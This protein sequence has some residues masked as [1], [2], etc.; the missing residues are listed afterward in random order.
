MQTMLR[1]RDNLLS[2]LPVLI[3]TLICAL[4]ILCFQFEQ[5]ILGA[6][7][8]GFGFCLWFACEWILIPKHPQT[9]GTASDPFINRLICFFYFS[10]LMSRGLCPAWFLGLQI[11]TTL[12][13][14]LGLFLLNIS[15]HSITRL[16]EPLSLA[17]VTFQRTT[18]GLLFLSLSPIN[19]HYPYV[20]VMMT[21]VALCSFQVLVFFGHLKHYRV[22]L[23]R[24]LTPSLGS[25]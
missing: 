21:Y 12:L 22:Q 10:L 11:A 23:I 1:I 2:A 25:V 7:L 17:N 18:L 16:R 20:V 14:S 9:L 19:V 24:L 3:N 8:Y 6:S 4:C 13:L 15:H 5:N